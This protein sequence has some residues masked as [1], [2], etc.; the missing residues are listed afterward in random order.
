MKIVKVTFYKPRTCKL[1]SGAKS[2]SY[3]VDNDK[4]KDPIKVA[5]ERFKLEHKN[6]KYYDVMSANQEVL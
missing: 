1:T 6:R 3:L 2:I 5:E 4:H